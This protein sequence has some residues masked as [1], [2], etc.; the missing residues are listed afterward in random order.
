MVRPPFFPFSS[1]SVPHP[2]SITFQP[3]PT[4]S[5][6]LLPP[7]LQLQGVLVQLCYVCARTSLRLT[8]DLLGPDPHTNGY[9]LYTS[10]NLSDPFFII[11][12]WQLPSC[13]TPFSTLP[14]HYIDLTLT[15]IRSQL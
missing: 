15:R 3:H 12:N 2:I 10:Y 13:L 5:T 11:D 4:L 9:C 8:L 6:C 1:L 14:V 7:P